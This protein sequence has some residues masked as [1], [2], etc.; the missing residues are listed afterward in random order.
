MVVAPPSSALRRAMPAIVA[1]FLVVLVSY[2][3]PFLVVQ[4]AAKNAGLTASQ[5]NGSRPCR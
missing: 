5:T 4:L 1:G 2:S 3:G